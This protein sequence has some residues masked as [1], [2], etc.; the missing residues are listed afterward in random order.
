[1]N[2]TGAWYAIDTWSSASC[3]A[4]SA[5]APRSPAAL[6]ARRTA[7]GSRSNACATASTTS[8]SRR[9]MRSSPV[10]I[11]TTYVASSGSVQAEKMRSHRMRRRFCAFLPDAS[12]IS[13]SSA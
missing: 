2:A 1:M 9:P 3:F 5:T 6:A 8:P 4:A 7:R 12:A 10:M 13:T 11:L